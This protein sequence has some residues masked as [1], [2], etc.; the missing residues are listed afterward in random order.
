MKVRNIKSYYFN[1]IVYGW[2]SCLDLTFS[3]DM[4]G[5]NPKDYLTRENLRDILGLEDIPE[6]TGIVDSYYFVDPDE[7]TIHDGH[8]LRISV[9][10]DW[11]YKR[12]D[13]DDGTKLITFVDIHDRVYSIS[14]MAGY[15]NPEYDIDN[16]DSDIPYWLYEDDENLKAYSWEYTLDEDE[17]VN[18]EIRDMLRRH[19]NNKTLAYD[20]FA[21]NIVFAM[22]S[23]HNPN[24]SGNE[25]FRDLT[26]LSDFCK[27][28]YEKFND[29][30]VTITYAIRYKRGIDA[31]L[32]TLK[33]IIIKHKLNKL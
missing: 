21:G 18:E 1:R 31:F 27:T 6:E 3:Y 22:I 5:L 13:D 32:S 26:Q 7:S 25:L 20:L 16:Y 30:S 11:H 29:D 12:D 24:S 19:S 2:R 4:L 33:S 23:G 9:D 28:T 15:V 10:V 8:K 17:S 14:G